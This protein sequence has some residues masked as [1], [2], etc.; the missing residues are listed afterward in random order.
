MLSENGFALTFDEPLPFGTRLEPRAARFKAGAAEP[1]A[2]PP[3]TALLRSQIISKDGHHMPPT[4]EEIADQYNRVGKEVIKFCS[5]ATDRLNQTSTQ[6]NQALSKQND[7]IDLQN[8]EASARLMAIEQKLVARGAGGS[9]GSDGDP[10]DVG[11]T[12]INSEGFKRLQ[13]GERES[14][15]IKV[16]SL[17]L[18]R[19]TTVVSGP[20]SSA[21]ERIPGIVSASAS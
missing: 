14:G 19:K 12:I 13:A 5:E 17:G 11:N 4:Q 15:Q 16:G 10:S 21:L 18:E 9:Y 7:K 8:R 6:L 1:L 20:W 3:I 2:L